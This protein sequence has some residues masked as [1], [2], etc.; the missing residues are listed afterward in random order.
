[1]TSAK[2]MRWLTSKYTSYNISQVPTGNLNL[3]G[4]GNHWYHIACRKKC[5]QYKVTINNAATEKYG[6]SLINW[7]NK[8]ENPNTSFQCKGQVLNNWKI[9][10]EYRSHWKLKL[11]REK[12][13]WTIKAT[14]QSQKRHQRKTQP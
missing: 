11:E 4:N 14:L 2:D 1:M 12:E 3:Q 10:Q 9:K 5:R 6:T 7:Y 13:K 8:V